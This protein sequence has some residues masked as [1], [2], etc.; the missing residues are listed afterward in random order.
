LTSSRYAKRWR[1]EIPHVS[2]EV[3]IPWRAMA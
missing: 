1:A 3:A 2:G